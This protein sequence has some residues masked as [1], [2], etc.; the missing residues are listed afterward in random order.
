MIKKIAIIGI[1]GTGKSTLARSLSEQLQIPV[2]HADQ[3]IWDEQWEEADLE[4]AEQKFRKSLDTESW[5][6]E[7]YIH[8]CAKKRLQDADLIL[9]LDYPGRVAMIGG[10]K[11]WWKYRGKKR[12]EM[13]DGC[14]EGQGLDWSYLKV[15]YKRG[16]RSEIEEALQLGDFA[17][18]LIRLTSRKETQKYI[19]SLV[20]MQKN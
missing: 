17:K 8:P 19:R 5:I 11:R 10:V 16:E 18:K 12:P 4:K 9:Y 15:M 20:E 3:Y 7:G 14:T 13:P 2:L 1:S 6:A